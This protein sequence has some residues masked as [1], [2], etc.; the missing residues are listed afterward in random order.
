MSTVSEANNNQHIRTK[1]MH[2]HT[3]SCNYY[4]SNRYLQLPTRVLLKGL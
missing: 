1:N 3:P 2:V 4:A